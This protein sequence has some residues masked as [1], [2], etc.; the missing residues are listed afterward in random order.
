L[1]T[2]SQARSSSCMRRSRNGF[3]AVTFDCLGH[4][5]NSQPTIGNVTKVEEG[6]APALVRE[7]GKVAA[8]ARSLPGGDGRIAVLGHSVASGIVIRYAQAHLEVAA[9]VAVSTF[10]PV[11]TPTSPRNLSEIII[12]LTLSGANPPP[13]R[14]N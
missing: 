6:P 10:S 2:A 12:M 9:T 7:F 5:H 11:V 14:L 13:A 4:G 1:P 3:I 8:F